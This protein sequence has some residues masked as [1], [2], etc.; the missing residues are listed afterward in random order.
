MFLRFGALGLLVTCGAFAQTNPLPPDEPPPEDESLI[1]VVVT[2]NRR[3]QPIDET[4]TAITVIDR[5]EIERLQLPSVEAALQRVPGVS[6]SNNGGRGKSTSVF[7]RGTESDHALVLIDGVRVGSATLGTTALENLPIDQIERIEVVRGSRS[8]LYGSEAI[9]G[10]IQIFTRRGSGP[11]TPYGRLGFGT[12]QTL[13]GAVGVQGG[14]AVR[15]FN[16]SVSGLRTDGFNAC[17]GVPNLAGCFTSEPDKD[18]YQN[19]SINATGSYQLSPALEIGGHWLRADSEVDFDGGFV[20]ESEAVQQVLGLN[21]RFAATDRWA[22]R[23]LLGYSEDDS[24]NFKDGAFRSR[25]KT[26]RWNVSLQNEVQLAPSQIGIVGIDFLRDQVSGST[27]FAEDERDNVGGFGQYQGQFGAFKVQLSGRYDDNSQFGGNSTGGASLGYALTP[28]VNVFA[29]LS[30]AFKAPSFN[31]LYFPGFGNPNLSPEESRAFE[32]GLNGRANGVNWSVNGYY[33]TID[34]LIAFDGNLGLPNN[35]NEARIYGVEASAQ[36]QQLGINWQLD[37]TLLNTENRSQGANRGNE[38]PRRPNETV[39]LSL[40]KQFS[41]FS[42]GLTLFAA[43][44]R[45]EDLSNTRRLGGYA[46]A[47]LRGSYRLARDLFLEARI[48]NLFDKDYET[49]A[50]YNQPGR[51]LFAQIRYQP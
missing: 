16:L 7:I 34:D 25:F 14:D 1:T 15:R 21:G 38:L 46:T 33:T 19:L 28:D 8:S 11:M 26:E 41:R 23:G 22:I 51:A 49:A 18:G 39:Q 29:G 42:L 35:V 24:D 17:D 3:E 47:D 50:F 5:D 32:L 31:E 40:D 10:V 37:G 48:T 27:K 9:G 6:I 45:Y 20:N 2:A 13:E 36:G 12:D 4:L 43:G 30:T 44:R